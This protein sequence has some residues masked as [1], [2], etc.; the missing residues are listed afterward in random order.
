MSASTF[1]SR[2]PRSL[3]ARL[4][5][6]TA[7]LLLASACGSTATPGAGTSPTI[8]TTPGG[9][10]CVAATS[11]GSVLVDSKG[12]TVYLLA[13]DTPG[14][15]TCDAQCLQVWPPVTAPVGKVPPGVSAP[16]GVTKAASGASILTA[17]GW[18]LYTF[19]GDRAPGN[20]NGQGIVNFGGTWYVVSPSGEAVKAAPTSAP[21]DDRGGIGGY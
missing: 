21:A 17:G 15:S 16:L 2:L 9:V 5:A 11:L 18:P 19:S 10:L 7:I 14:R 4:L 3:G 20:V 12:M 1:T 8:V 13:A 6:A